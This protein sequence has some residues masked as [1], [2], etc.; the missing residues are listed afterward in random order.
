MKQTL[1]IDGRDYR[2]ALR[3]RPGRSYRLV[4]VET[5]DESD[6]LRA[7]SWD[8][9]DRDPHDFPEER[10]HA[11][12]RHA[13]QHGW[14]TSDWHSLFDIHDAVR[15]PPPPPSDLPAPTASTAT[16]RAYWRERLGVFSIGVL[17]S[18]Y[19]RWHTGRWALQLADAGKLDR[20]L[21]HL[22]FDPLSPGQ[23]FAGMEVAM[24][25]LDDVAP[26]ELPRAVERIRT[27]LVREAWLHAYTVMQWTCDLD[28]WPVRPAVRLASEL[29]EAIYDPE[30]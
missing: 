9:G 10:L 3:H 22:A 18:P 8:A 6:L 25:M 17:V 4:R 5:A 16:D 19:P 7:V 20:L 30:F 14:G 26:A 11:L 29:H 1:T 13:R 12:V 21:D 28:P 27:L 23:R 24:A 2:W 15:L